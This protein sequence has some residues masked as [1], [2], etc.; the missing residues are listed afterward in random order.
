[1]GAAAR[2]QV[3]ATAIRRMLD[4]PRPGPT[5]TATF[6]TVAGIQPRPTIGDPQVL[7]GAAETIGVYGT[8]PL[9]FPDAGYWEA[10]VRFT[11]DG[12]ARTFTAAFS[13][14]PP[15]WIEAGTALAVT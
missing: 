8:D 6:I 10:T 14:L 11:T 3:T 9:T 2:R 15:T 12:R 4:G 5:A 7:D 13:P 1:M